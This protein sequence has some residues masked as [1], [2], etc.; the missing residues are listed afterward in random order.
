[1]LINLDTASLIRKTKV[2]ITLFITDGANYTCRRKR[3]TTPL[4]A[5]EKEKQ[6]TPLFDYHCI[7]IRRVPREF[8]V[9]QRNESCI[10]RL[11]KG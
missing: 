8:T 1:M 5:E 11:E 6:I 10:R 3:K 9:S 7:A 4:L 2:F